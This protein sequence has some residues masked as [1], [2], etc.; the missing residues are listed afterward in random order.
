VI[1]LELPATNVTGKDGRYDT[2]KVQPGT[3][4]VTARKPMHFTPASTENAEATVALAGGE[5][6]EIALVLDATELHMHVDADRDGTADDD[7]TGLDKWEWGKGKKG[8]IILCNNDDDAGAGASDN[9]DDKINGGNDASELAPLE[10]RLSGPKPPA[11]VKAFLKVSD[12]KFVRIFDTKAAGTVEVIGPTSG[13][14]SYEFP[15]LTFAKREFGIEAVR[16]AD[17]AFSGTVVLTFEV[18][19]AG[20][21]VYDEKAELRVAPWMMPNHLDKA[22]IVYV[23][24]FS[25]AYPPV[26]GPPPAYDVR[27]ND[28]FRT[29]L[30]TFITAAGCTLVTHAVNDQWMQDCMEFGFSSLPSTGF[31]TTS[32]AY[33]KRGL[34]TYPRTLRKADLGYHEE[35]R[36]ADPRDDTTFDSTGNLECT[37]PVTS[38]AGKHYPWGRI[39]FGPGRPA[40]EMNPKV[41]DFLK[42]QTVQAPIPVDTSWLAVGHVDEFIGIAPG[43]P[44]GFKLLLA[45]PKLAYKVLTANKAASGASKLL[46]GRKFPE[47]NAA[48]DDIIGWKD[49]EVTI[50]GFLTTGIPN[51][52]L[53]AAVL[54]SFNDDKQAKID[55][56]RKDLKKELG[57]DE[58]DII[59]VPVLFRPYE[60]EPALAEAL[61]GDTVNMLVVNK[62][63]IP[64][65][66]FGPV[67]GG[68]D[69]FEEELKSALTPLGLT[70]K[71]LDDW[72]EYHVAMGEVH[73]GT[74]TLRK[75]PSAKWWEFT[76]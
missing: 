23:V 63:C 19:K 14:S 48:G 5:T 26:G 54:K 68:K 64:P 33:R 38:K 59:D 28:R 41:V 11:D 45:S 75:Q 36:F 42:E 62:H 31:R 32:A 56:T 8:A 40:E 3:F 50:S 51:L 74:N 6:K 12:H 13:K 53:T 65:K 46:T 60:R 30:D 16:Y 4:H 43:G 66:A 21:T 27:S 29:E 17:G 76:P 35:V 71:F 1:I 15:N 9:S 20:A 24:K 70:V 72:Y 18:Q 52:G 55:D 73:C 10:F 49:A 37:P 25:A 44:K 58:P 34:Q 69:L 7:R 22:E 39:Y 67:V 47:W 57:L 2:G 61:T